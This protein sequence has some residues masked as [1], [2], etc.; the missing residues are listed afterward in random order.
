M[1]TLDYHILPLFGQRSF[2]VNPIAR[3]N[4]L[5]SPFK[6]VSPWN[7]L[8]NKSKYCWR[9][10][11]RNSNATLELGV[12]FPSKEDQSEF[13]VAMGWKQNDLCPNPAYCHPPHM[14]YVFIYTTYKLH[15]YI[16]ISFSFSSFLCSKTYIHQ[17]HHKNFQI[18]L[19]STR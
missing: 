19:F 12:H 15:Y 7:F 2:C 8:M 6:L 16:P 14:Y 13:S 5:W 18:W 17:R 3:L 1:S 10:F 4:S 11:A 9:N